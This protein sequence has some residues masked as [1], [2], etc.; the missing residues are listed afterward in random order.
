MKTSSKESKGHISIAGTRYGAWLERLKAIGHIET[1]EFDPGPYMSGDDLGGPLHCVAR[2]PEDPSGAFAKAAKEVCDPEVVRAVGV[3]VG[4]S[5]QAIDPESFLHWLDEYLM[6]VSLVRE[7]AHLIPGKA[8]AGAEQ[9]TVATTEKEAA[10]IVAE[11]SADMRKAERLEDRTVPR[12]EVE[13]TGAEKEVREAEVMAEVA[14]AKVEETRPSEPKPESQRGGLFA[15]VP[16]DPRMLFLIGLVELIVTTVM[17]EPPVSDLIATE[18]P[19]GSYLMAAGISISVLGA[20]GVA[21]F[22]LAAVRLPAKWVAAFM[23]AVFALLLMKLVTGLDALRAGAESGVETLTAATLAAAYVSAV[24]GYAIATWRDSE[25]MRAS[26]I[27]PG[28]RLGDA[29]AEQSDAMV[30][31][32]VAKDRL[33]NAR[34]ALS[35]M[36]ETIESLHDSAVRCDSRALAREA[37]GVKAGVKTAT[38]D[39]VTQAQVRQE[40][41]SHMQWARGLSVLAYLKA[42]AEDLPVGEAIRTISAAPEQVSQGLSALQKSAIAVFVIGAVG[43]VSYGPVS[44]VCGAL[45]TGVLL[46][47]DRYRKKRARDAAAKLAL[48]VRPPS[49]ESAATTDNPL[50]VPQ[51][52]H[53]VQKYGHGGS[54]HGESN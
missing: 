29:M 23:V 46:L 22:C 2:H 51:P 19:F 14:R 34:G 9:E 52:D 42:R 17:L 15:R 12:L 31:L 21:G 18:M 36:W 32:R 3:D 24:T 20:S 26:V 49:I 33:A 13:I 39:A 37:V 7:G 53:M 43:G 45:V 30:T 4:S 40:R 5:S 38:I 10:A 47:V 8:N 44:L 16:F 50:Y 1:P 35:E 6:G 41:A 54:T 11:G 27:A 25:A 28:T 48:L